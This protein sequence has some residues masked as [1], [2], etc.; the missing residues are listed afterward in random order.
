MSVRASDHFNI[1]VRSHVGKPIFT[2]L[3]SAKLLHRPTQDNALALHIH[4]LKLC[5]F[6][7]FFLFF[8]PFSKQV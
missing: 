3:I 6:F 7:S 2:F 1:E 5:G 4:I 8:S